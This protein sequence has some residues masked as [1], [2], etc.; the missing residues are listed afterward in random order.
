MIQTH[1][2]Q[3]FQFSVSFFFLSIILTHITI[4]Y[5]HTVQLSCIILLLFSMNL[6]F[7]L[8]TRLC[9]LL[10]TSVSVLGCIS[11]A[12][13]STT[14][15]SQSYYLLVFHTVLSHPVDVNGRFFMNIS[16]LY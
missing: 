11:S 3:G 16:V 1:V 4:P 7:V 2:A 14:F 6:D 9:E 8:Y 10:S 12:A 15:L 13:F 5:F